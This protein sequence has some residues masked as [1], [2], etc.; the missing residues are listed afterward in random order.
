VH[1]PASNIDVAPKGQFTCLAL[2]YRS[3]RGT[4]V[5][6]PAGASGSITQVGEQGV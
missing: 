1:L 6:L 2:A 3:L 5:A 4:V